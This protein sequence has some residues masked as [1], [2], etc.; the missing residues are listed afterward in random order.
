MGRVDVVRQGVRGHAAGSERDA[1]EADAPVSEGVG[2]LMIRLYHVG[3]G[4]A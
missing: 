1:R 4:G 2:S 3:P